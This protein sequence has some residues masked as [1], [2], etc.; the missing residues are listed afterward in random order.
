MNLRRVATF[1]SIKCYWA[2]G[3]T[4][5]IA[6]AYKADPTAGHSRRLTSGGKPERTLPFEAT[7]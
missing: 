3:Q 4:K 2:K 1:E 5:G 6:Q 7:V